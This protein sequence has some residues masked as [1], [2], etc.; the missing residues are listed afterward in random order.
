MWVCWNEA[1]HLC[2]TGKNDLLGAVVGIGDS[3]MGT[4]TVPTSHWV[5]NSSMVTSVGAAAIGAYWT[6]VTPG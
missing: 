3:S 6:N 4:N 2:Q 5:D 1:H